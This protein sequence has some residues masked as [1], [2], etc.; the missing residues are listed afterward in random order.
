L[1]LSHSPRQKQTRY[2]HGSCLINFS[3]SIPSVFIEETDDHE[4]IESTPEVGRTRTRELHAPPT[5]PP[6]TNEETRGRKKDNREKKKRKERSTKKID[7]FDR[8]RRKKPA[9]GST[10]SLNFPH[11]FPS[12]LCYLFCLEPSNPQFSNNNQEIERSD[13]LCCL[14]FLFKFLD[15][16]ISQI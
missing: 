6:S 4:T 5:D 9:D 13:C 10:G 8:R 16:C 12:C 1:L 2:Q 15:F 7:S 3:C 14:L 11:F